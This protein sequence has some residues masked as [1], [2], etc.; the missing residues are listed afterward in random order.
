MKK[1]IKS[2]QNIFN[3][4]FEVSNVLIALKNDYILLYYFTVFYL[5]CHITLCNICNPLLHLDKKIISLTFCRNKYLNLKT[6]K[7]CTNFLLNEEKRVFPYLVVMP[8]RPVVLALLKLLC[9]LRRRGIFVTCAL[10]CHAISS[11]P[12]TLSPSHRGTPNQ[13][14]RQLPNSQ[15]SSAIDTN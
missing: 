14:H 10:L 2:L 4:T 6:P 1:I 15:S 7:H 8:A 9:S 13:L 3:F 5:Y 11:L 12:Q